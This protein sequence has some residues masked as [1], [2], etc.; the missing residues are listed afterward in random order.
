MNGMLSLT[1]LVE[2]LHWP[3]PR[4][5]WEAARQL[6]QLV[7]N[8]DDTAHDMLLAWSSKQKLESDAAILPSLVHAFELG[9]HFTFEDLNR[10]VT[11]PSI[12][13]DALLGTL[14]P[15]EVGRLLSLRYDYT[16]PV[17]R[18]PPPDQS[19]DDGLGTLVPAIFETILRDEQTRT[20]LPFLD[21]W[22]GEWRRLQDRYAEAYTPYPHYFFAN[23]R[24][25]RGS[26]DVRQRAVFVSA[27]L[28][29]LS[30]AH[31]EWRMPRNYA[32]G[33]AAFALP[34]NGGVAHFQTSPRPDWSQ[35]FLERFET[36]NATTFA[37]DVWHHAAAS[38]EAGFEP[39]ALDV[40]DHHDN[41]AV[42][43]QVQ[44]VIEG[45]AQEG[46]LVTTPA[47]PAWVSTQGSA[48]SLAGRLPPASHRSE[49]FGLRPLCVAAHPETP[50]RAHIDLLL[51]RLLVADP[52]LATGAATLVCEADRIELTDSLGLLS[53]LR[54]WYAD[55]RPTHP[56]EMGWSGSLTTCRSSALRKFR[57]TF[58]VRTPRTVRV[59]VARR[60][61]SH[62]PFE[63][64]T[65]NFR[66]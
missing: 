2:R 58:A 57:R 33:M 49:V 19:F 16:K 5:R 62:Q 48:W 45:D 40:I 53:T 47:P 3:V 56:E 32:I 51:D 6:A 66:L 31:L 15:G 43:V 12:L 39:I 54:L 30:A 65:Q 35:G 22:R 14:Y 44:R 55:W 17:H 24:G 59:Q 11:S 46:E 8:G 52:Q 27:F 25:S 63:I 20:N 34:F 41:F 9:A 23:D 61:Y 18:G 36:K 21:Q 42:R 1:F 28:R 37:R 60:P 7:R 26:L 64:E 50:A 4:V 13:S 38:I 29:T 10:A